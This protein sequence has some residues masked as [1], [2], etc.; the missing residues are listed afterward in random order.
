[1]DEGFKLDI[2]SLLPALAE[3]N[4][5]CG[6]HDEW[7]HVCQVIRDE[8]WQADVNE[9]VNSLSKILKTIPADS[10]IV[11]DVGNNEFWMSRACVYAKV[12]N[13]TLYS[14]SFGALGNA[15][16]KAIGA[17]YAT[18]KPVVAFVGDQ[19][20][21][22]NIQELQ[23]IA[24]HHLP[25][26]V[27]VLNNASSGMIKDREA[28]AGY[29]YSLH[30]TKNSGYGIPCFSKIAEGYGLKY[31]MMNENFSLDEISSPILVELQIPESQTLTPSLPRGR[32]M[33]DLEPRIDEQIY[34]TL[35]VL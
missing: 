2:V 6:K 15:L 18:Q 11:N 28:I 32:D 7:L 17:Y 23:Y 33:Q 25:V 20:I 30:T 34:N 5:D 10:I 8:L 9:A 21:Q 29:G 19:G 16:G 27:V 24:Q 14:K 3:T 12:T 4:D 13:R 1:M 26:V 22:M 31:V 35:N